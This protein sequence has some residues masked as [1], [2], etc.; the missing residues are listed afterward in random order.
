MDPLPTVWFLILGVMLTLYVILDGGDLGI[1]ILTLFT[2][3]EEHRKTMID[4]ISP[5][6]YSNETWL[7]VAGAT[8][9][10]AFPLA[11]GMIFN[12]LYIPAITILIGLIF[13]A[14]SLEFRAFA[15]TKKF[16]ER[17]FGVGSLIA[18]IGEGSLLGG[19]ASGLKNDGKSFTGGPWDW[20]GL[21][22]MLT[23]VGA[24]FGLVTIAYAYLVMKTE[25]SF[26]QLNYRRLTASSFLT[27]FMYAA[28]LIMLPFARLSFI[29]KWFSP[30]GRTL[31]IVFS[32]VIVWLFFMLIMSSYRRKHDRAPF[33]WAIVVFLIAMAGFLYGNYPY[34]IPP[35]VTIAAASSP[36]RTQLF[37]LVGV[38]M[39][40][41]IIL[42][43]SMYMQGVFRGKVHGAEGEG[44]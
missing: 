14:V 35:D 28:T 2:R 3:E 33:V 38:G 31:F 27:F 16:W 39:I 7:V 30:S 21:L 29:N 24:I 23:T 43:Y 1:G 26:Q 11:Y 10:G 13:R 32:T 22:S 20:F 40:V 12:A 6:W 5:M 8:L 4:S 42:V 37:M 18:I 44:Y 19:I 36:R 15:S 25:G 41:P 17:S 9:F 34:I